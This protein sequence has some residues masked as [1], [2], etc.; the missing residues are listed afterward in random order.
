VAS[1]Y[2]PSLP[3]QAAVYNALMSGPAVVEAFQAL[4]ANAADTPRVFDTVPTGPDGQITALFPYLVIGL[5]QIVPHTPQI[6]DEAIVSVEVWSRPVVDVDF[7]EMKTLEGAVRDTLSVCL[8]VA[9]F[10]TSTWRFHGSI[11]R[12]EPD[13]I[14]RR[15]IL[16][17]SYLLTP[18]AG[19]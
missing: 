7:G 5:D 14:T 11:P 15:Q 16:T 18:A 8:P 10:Q 9:R 19:V 13:G 2:S 6:T 12:K 1:V 4:Q 3:L 17:M